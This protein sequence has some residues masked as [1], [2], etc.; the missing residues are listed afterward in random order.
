MH[1]FAASAAMRCGVHPG[2]I[3]INLLLNSYCYVQGKILF[4]KREK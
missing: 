1:F 4:R 3:F 2:I